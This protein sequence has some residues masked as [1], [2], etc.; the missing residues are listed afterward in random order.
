[1]SKFNLKFVFSLFEN[2]IPRYNNYNRIGKV[3]TNMVVNDILSTKIS[4][5]LNFDMK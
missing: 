2:G 1:M 5:R 4:N 3:Y